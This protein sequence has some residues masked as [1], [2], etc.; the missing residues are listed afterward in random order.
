[1][2]QGG[3][4][5]DQI[6]KSYIDQVFDK[7]DTDKSHTLD[8]KEMTSFFNDLFKS[9]NMPI[10]IT[11]QQALEAIRS[12]DANYD[13]TVNKEELFNAFKAMIDNPQQPQQ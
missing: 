6:L 8:Q 13:G 12:I 5:K 4:F 3:G 10:V 1:M 7:Y 2:L 11:E 9:L